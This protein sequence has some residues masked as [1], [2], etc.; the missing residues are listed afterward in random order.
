VVLQ[1]IFGVNTHIRE[2]A[3]GYADAG[4][5]AVAPATFHRV[6]AGVELGY[7]GEDMQAG[8][9]LKA[10][11]EALPAPGVL[12]DIE[13]A[14]DHAARTSGGKVG[15]AGYCWG[16]LLAWRTACLVSGV[17]AAAAYYG[18]GVTTEAEAARQPRCPVMAHFG[19]KDHWIPMESVRAFGQEDEITSKHEHSSA[20]VNTTPSFMQLH[21][22]PSMVFYGAGVCVCC[23]F[24][25]PVSHSHRV[26]LCDYRIRLVPWLCATSRSVAI[27]LV[28][29]LHLDRHSCP[30]HPLTELKRAVRKGERPLREQPVRSRLHALASHAHALEEVKLHQ[31]LYEDHEQ[32]TLM[33]IPVTLRNASTCLAHV[34]SEGVAAKYSDMNSL[35][36]TD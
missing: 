23:F 4:Y 12:A 20:M 15:V 28:S 34:L 16:G 3:Q 9:A 24:L 33:F 18:G 5:L 6:Q 11:V 32:W 29:L 30:L 22:I 17:A 27:R 31:E 25:M 35:I 1:E 13:A 14:V 8:I 10:A 21:P 26:F 36:Q 7:T 2:V 19:E